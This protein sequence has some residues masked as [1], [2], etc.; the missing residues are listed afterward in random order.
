[1]IH[2][3]LD[4]ETTGLGPFTSPE[5]HDQI[6]EIA[7]VWNE[8]GKIKYIQEFSNPGM[9][10]LNNADEALNIQGRTIDEIKSYQ[11]MATASRNVKKKLSTLQD[12]VYHS[13][14]IPFDRYFL[15]QDPWNLSLNWGEDPMIMA[16]RYM[17]YSY[18]RIALSK[19]ADYFEIEMPENFRFHTALADAYMAMKIWEVISNEKM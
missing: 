10:Y 11:D 4:T 17:G 18:D 16:S 13:W 19:A 12:P 1:M 3:F 6:I 15:E 5:R 8:N 7:F 2:V 9:E 14:N